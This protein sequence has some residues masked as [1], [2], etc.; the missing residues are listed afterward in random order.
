MRFDGQG[1]FDVQILLGVLPGFLDVT[2]LFG[3]APVTLRVA[4]TFDTWRSGCLESG[5]VVC[6]KGRE[7]KDEESPTP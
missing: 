1:L 7:R 6:W 3:V 5:W 2:L 4:P